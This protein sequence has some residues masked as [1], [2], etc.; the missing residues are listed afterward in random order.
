MFYSKRLLLSSYIPNTVVY[1]FKTPQVNTSIELTTTGYY[2]IIL[3]GAG[4]LSHSIYTGDTSISYSWHGSGGRGWTHTSGATGGAGGLATATAYLVE[5]TYKVTIGYLQGVESTASITQQGKTPNNA[6]GGYER[7]SAFKTKDG[8]VLMQANG[9]GKPSYEQQ[10]SQ[11]NDG[12]KY[13]F[14]TA[15]PGGTATISSSL[16]TK[17]KAV[18]TGASGELWG[19]A[20]G[21]GSWQTMTSAAAYGG[22]GKAHN[23][24]FGYDNYSYQTNHVCSGGKGGYFKLVYVGLD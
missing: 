12:A 20:G 22:Y 24:K 7:N 23:L 6:F 8:T 3:V 16:I 19:N 21:Q 10:G 18:T 15:A 2:D 11:K 5:G 4:G 9:G 13:R 14:T 1:E 17:V